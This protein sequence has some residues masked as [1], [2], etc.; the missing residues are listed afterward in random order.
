M[1]REPAD[2]FRRLVALL[3]REIGVIDARNHVEITAKCK[4]HSGFFST[5][6]R[7]V[8]ARDVFQ[9]TKRSSELDRITR[10]LESLTGL[11]LADIERAFR[12][13]RWAGPG[14]TCAYGGP[15]WAAIAEATIALR[16]AIISAN[17]AE[18]VLLLARIEDLQH[19]NGP[20]VQKFPELGPL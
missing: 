8:M 13:G 20:V 18:V 19:N 4:R 17:T 2:T 15:K 14:G 16:A 9:D 7:K 3:Y 6:A 1:N 5:P 11:S 10:K 12:E